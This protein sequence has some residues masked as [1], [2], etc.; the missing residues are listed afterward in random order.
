[1]TKERLQPFFCL[2]SYVY[3]LWPTIKFLSNL[4]IGILLSKNKLRIMT[5]IA[6]DQQIEAIKK[7]TQEALKSPETALKFLIDAG[8][9]KAKTE[10]TQKP[11]EEKQK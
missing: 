7:V 2:V 8:I 5:Q 1:M 9:I 11:A 6:I 10:T 4:R 3:C